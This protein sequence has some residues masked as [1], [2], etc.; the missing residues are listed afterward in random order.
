MRKLLFTLFLVVL[1]LPLSS[2]DIRILAI[3]N[4][5]SEDAV[6]QYLYELALEG[7]DNLI[8]GNA[9][10]GGQG[11]ESHWTVVLADQADFEYRKVV[12]GTKTNNRKTLKECIE[13]EAWDYITFQQVSQDSGRPETYEPYLGNLLDYAKGLATNPDVKF[14]LHQTWAYAKNSTHSGFANYGNEQQTMYAAIVSAVNQ[15][16]ETHAELSFIV[17]SGTAIQNGRTSFIGDN[18]NR[19]GYHLDYGVGRYTAACTW[20]E[21]I[22]GQSPVG[23]QYRPSGVN[24]VAAMVAQSAA[25]AAIATPNEVTD[26]ANAGYDGDNTFVP[27]KPVYLNFGSVY[28]NGVWK[29]SITPSNKSI[30]GLKD[31]DG[32]DTQIVTLLDDEFTGTNTEGV[33]QTTTALNLPV[34][35]A[36]T[37]IWGY[38]QGNFENQPQ[39]VT[40]GCI[41]FHLNKDLV[42]DFCIFG[43]R[44]GVTDNRETTYT[45]VGGNTRKGSLNTAANSSET[46]TIK[47][48]RPTENGEIRLTAGPGE[49][50]NNQYKFYYLNALQV[51]A[52][53]AEASDFV[54]EISS[55]SDLLSM[56]SH[57][58]Y[59]LTADI[60]LTGVSIS[61]AVLD[62]YYG[63][64]DGQGHVIYG[65]TIDK[66]SSGE[67]GMFRHLR[68]GTIKNLGLERASILGNTNVG[69]FAGQT[70]G[71]T[72]ENCYIA[73]SNIAGRDHV[74]ALVGQLEGNSGVGSRI[75]NCYAAA[76]VYSR[77]NQG[78]GLVGTST[79]GAGSI[80][81]CY[82]SGRVE[83][84]G[85]RIGGILGLQ[86]SDDMITI[87]NCATLAT[88][89][90]CN[91][92]YR[93]AST[94]DGKS[95]L[96]NNYALSTLPTPNGNDDQKGM[97]VTADRAKEKA[98]Y[99][100]DLG[101]TF[102]DATWKWNDGIYPVLA[103]QKTAETVTPLV[104][105]SQSAPILSLK[106]GTSIDLSNYYAS[107]NGGTLVYS[108]T[109]NKIKV[110][111]SLVSIAEAAEIT[112]LETVII[113]ASV[114]G[115][116]AAELSIALAPEIIP[117]ATAEDFISRIN[118]ATNASFKLT[119][120]LD[121][122]GVSFNGIE[123]FSGIL[124]GNGFIIK[125]LNI[126]REGEGKLGLF[127]STNGA[128]IKNLGIENST[129]GTADNKHIGAFVGEMNGGS[130]SGCYV[131]NSRIVGKDHVGALVGQLISGALMS[132][133]YSTAYVQTTGWQIGGLVGSINNATVDKSYFSGVVVG[134]WEKT[135][136]LVGLK[137]GGDENTNLVNNS[138]NLASYIIGGT[139][140]RVVG[141]SGIKMENN[142]SLLSACVGG[143]VTNAAA[144]TSTD[145]TG[146]DGSDMTLE[147][148]RSASF[149]AETLQWDMTDTWSVPV[150]GES[151][152]VLKWQ[153][154][155]DG[156]I[157]TGLYIGTELQ[158]AQTTKN[159]YLAT[160]ASSLPQ[161]ISTH[162]LTLIFQSD[163]TE[164]VTVDGSTLTPAASGMAAVTMEINAGVSDEFITNTMVYN[165]KV[166][167]TE[168]VLEIATADELSMITTFPD[169]DYVLSNSIDMTGIA[170]SGL[171]SE[172]SPFTGTFDGQQYTIKGLTFDNANTSTMGLFRKI[173]G[174]T[175]KNVSLEEVN[176]IGN[177]NIGGIAGIADGGKIEFCN[178]TNSYIEGRD[179]AAGIAAWVSGGVV[180]ENCFVAGCDV[181]AREHQAG[182]ISAAALGGDVTI[183]NC[184]F[185][186]TITSQYGHVGS[187]LGLMD[188]DGDV[189]IENCL[190]LASSIAG[191][192]RF[193]IC[194]WG[195]RESMAHF[196]N[197][198]SISTTVSVGGDWG[199]TDARI[200]TDLPDDADAKSLDFYVATL[201]WDF[202]NIWTINDGVSYP[203]FK[204]NPTK[205]ATAEAFIE[206]INAD[207]NGTFVLTADLDFTG[208]VFNGIESFSG[209]L[210]G[211][212]HIIKNLNIQREGEGMLGLFLSTNGAEI[213]NLGIENSTI[214]TADN[215][216][217]GAF[218][219]EMNGGSIS[220]CY[221][222]TSR[223]VGK[224]HVGAL[225]GQLKS[226]ALMSNCYS[227]AYVQTTGW[228]A[229]GLVGSIENATVDQSYFSGVVV[230][231]WNRTGGLVGLKNGGD[232]TTNLVKNSVNLASYITGNDSPKRVVGDGGIKS[233]NNYS[234]SSTRIGTNVANAA[235]IT[236]TD[237][238]SQDGADM[239]LDQA[240]SASFYAETL[241]WD[242]TDTWA[243]TAT[244]AYPVLKWQ[245][246]RADKLQWNIYEGIDVMSE[247]TPKAIFL[248]TEGYDLA[249]FV[250]SNGLTLSYET[251]STNV[252]IEGT[253][254]TTEAA[255]G[256]AVITISTDE[257][258]QAEFADVSA[259]LNCKI[260]AGTGTIEIATAEDLL[261]VN[262]FPGRDFVLTDNIDM[263]DVAFNGLCSEATPFT[264][265][266][267]GNKHIITGLTF[268]DANVSAM[269]LFRKI[270]GAT[271]KNVYLEEVEFN[272]NE[273]IGGIAG[274]ADGGKI[275]LCSVTNSYIEG[276][277]RAAGIV[278]YVRGGVVI[279]NCFVTSCDVKA[280]EH[281]AG[282]IAAAAYGEATIR[283]C[284]FEGTITSQYGHVGSMLG[285]IDADANVTIENCLNL[286]SSIIG[287]TPYRICSWGGRADYAQ[288]TN[289]YSIS[290]TAGCRNDADARNGENLPDDADATSLN[291]Y[292]ETLGWDFNN[293]WQIE[294]GQGYPTFRTIPVGFV[295]ATQSKATITVYPIDG[296]MEIVVAQPQ[297]VS[298][299][300][301][302]GSLV[303]SLMLS[304][305]HHTV[306][307][308]AN[309]LYLVNNVKVLVK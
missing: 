281:Q 182:G 286:A 21:K 270:Q 211:N 31:A 241:Q 71:G 140:K 42:Y 128:E 155:R 19:D 233:E 227:T 160:E 58:D 283:Y 146:Q 205:I 87:Q 123:S 166:I 5:F 102:D 40:G 61:E 136:G 139:F 82:F 142:Y 292:K 167:S 145:A 265:T 159:L 52:R 121:F 89:L 148:A 3:G 188:R 49:N 14:G 34:D 69:A 73:N 251:A 208:V 279:E 76:N 261:I 213:K 206:K 88:Q 262:A 234:L 232:E 273:N 190:N 193:R 252:K 176:F 125:N 54:E 6:E 268:N 33:Q 161:V 197:N 64:L 91:E 175:I 216:H 220:G 28:E 7:G 269:G 185:E 96:T 297:H 181:K 59:V 53:D 263:T 242:M 130:I 79:A 260:V 259:T 78:G 186:G 309:G 110:E 129:I 72:L 295:P 243:M 219:G 192:N 93:I 191:G 47:G 9:Y 56:D 300:T 257:A 307:G 2:K 198:Y 70:H 106:K 248:S 217:I 4:S 65:L 30:F 204:K 173:Q 255:S 108:C 296:G 144:I 163:N 212:G 101:W 200:G 196:T 278:A 127:L 43:S 48:V 225:V 275:E 84:V 132:N 223:I 24:E 245:L 308:I 134:N 264:G 74:G 62:S 187:M 178:V 36:K 20:L 218:V 90:V 86:D 299:Y 238:A 174:A 99:T 177:E 253:L 303:R 85:Q 35:V 289:N 172:S 32:N 67:V 122:A 77:E 141:D 23:K 149:Y 81:N 111:G 169:R 44:K 293:V 107:G 284:Y 276:R 170:F 147:Q 17:P 222:G 109:N 152:P 131:G 75:E 13:D 162:G 154:E 194:N 224:D 133:C 164:V 120:D 138:V 16:K 226:N 83:V 306:T 95:T 112:D 150:D 158:P 239:T 41:F 235:A 153:L 271:I 203:V 195:S 282:G 272:G 165:C 104:H 105:L 115:F 230:G 39:Q 63:T 171:C 157:Q 214:G 291:F 207:T 8:I 237:A 151:Y 266:F 57:T 45:L 92:M 209:I 119:A 189:T 294:D 228:Q 10:R 37:S 98:F 80:Q 103:W 25:H 288:F 298:I 97:D 46:V 287:G 305:G 15:A 244:A 210:D 236:S 250:A 304:E 156:K 258:A 254:L 180:I 229:G 240:R 256:S 50:N 26:Q 183:R 1:S 118:A 301:A 246:D 126:Q 55:A 18:F 27:S 100:D 221:V 116:K 66:I 22:T 117:V 124:D 60:D 51:V 201:N 179:R 199:S 231:Y 249:R 290:T 143:S 137:N 285:L 280:R 29:N 168:G 247:E 202:D 267:D 38:A 12:G 302:D 68:G 135:G 277:D 94:R 11:L 113:S 114:S 184:Y 274:I 215:K